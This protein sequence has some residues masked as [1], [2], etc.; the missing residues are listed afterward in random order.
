MSSPLDVLGRP[1]LKP[2]PDGPVTTALVL[3]GGGVTGIAWE[4][5][6]LKGLRDAGIDVTAADTVIGT[7]AGSVVGAQV[8]SRLDLDDL[9]ASQLRPASGEVKAD[10]GPGMLARLAPL[11]LLPGS[12]QTKRRRIGQ[13]AVAAQPGPATE[14]LRVISQRLRTPKGDR[15]HWPEDR[16]LQITAVDAETGELRVF[17]RHGDVD[18]LHAVAASCAVP[19]VWPPVVI[20]GRPYVDGGARSATN[21]DLARER[22]IV[23]VIAPLTRSFSRHHTIAS[24]LGRTGARRTAVLSPDH[25]SLTAIGKNVLDPAKRPDAAKAGLAQAAKVAAEVAAGW[26]QGR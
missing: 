26:P 7:S 10:L 21:A 14:R 20:D 25:E 1:H 8:T 15:L 9:Y 4:L 18:L 19:I 22:D 6:L 13:A 2:L 16:D 24:Q 5:G 3:G 11:V 12:R 17:D 23:L